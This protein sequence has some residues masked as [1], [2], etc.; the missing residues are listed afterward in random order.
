MQSAVNSFNHV[1]VIALSYI[2]VSFICN[3]ITLGLGIFVIYERGTGQ[4][5]PVGLVSKVLFTF[6]RDIK[7][8]L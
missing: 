5:R 8:M 3:F 1:M 2:G 4:E 7:D 6:S